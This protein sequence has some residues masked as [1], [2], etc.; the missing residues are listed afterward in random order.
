MPQLY[1]E[2]IEIFHDLFNMNIGPQMD[3]FA[4]PVKLKMS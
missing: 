4:K 1:R 2:I 3:E